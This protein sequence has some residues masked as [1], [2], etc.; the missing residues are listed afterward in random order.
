MLVGG[1]F[2]IYKSV[3]RFIINWKAKTQCAKHLQKGVSFGRALVQIVVIDA[4]FSFDIIIT[5]GGTAKRV[6]IDWGVI[7]AMFIMFLFSPKSHHLSISIPL[8]CL[9]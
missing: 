1:L 9:R 7:I 8:R 3:H 6:E 4:V 2:L 5:A